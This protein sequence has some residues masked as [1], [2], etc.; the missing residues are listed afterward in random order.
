VI[1]SIHYT[2]VKTLYDCSLFGWVSWLVALVSAAL[3]FGSL[4]N[5][6]I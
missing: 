2:R 6:V 1:A 5:L 3:S 4:D